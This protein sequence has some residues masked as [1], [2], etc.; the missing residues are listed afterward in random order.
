MRFHDTETGTAR[1]AC[2]GRGRPLGFVFPGG[3]AADCTRFEE[4]VDTIKVRRAGPGRPRTRESDQ[5]AVTIASL[6]LWLKPL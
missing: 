1:V 5:A 6:F 2:D 4:V 3:N